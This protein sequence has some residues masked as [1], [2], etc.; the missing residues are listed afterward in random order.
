VAA[1]AEK[2]TVDR[3]DPGARK[4]IERLEENIGATSVKLTAGDLRDIENAASTITLQGAR[5]AE[6]QEKMIDR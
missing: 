5:Y 2:K 1:G 6:A 3:S 4:R